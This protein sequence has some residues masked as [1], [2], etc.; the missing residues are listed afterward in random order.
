MRAVNAASLRALE[1]LES[2]ANAGN[3]LLPTVFSVACSV[4]SKAGSVVLK[5]GDYECPSQYAG[6]FTP[7]EFEELVHFFQKVD[8]DGS[9]AL[10]Q[11]ELQQ[12]MAEMQVPYEESAV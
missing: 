8:E 3:G 11:T 10:D 4:T 7:L 2:N 9:G 12:L 5:L 1:V 6:A